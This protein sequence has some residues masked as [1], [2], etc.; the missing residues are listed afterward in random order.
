MGRLDRPPLRVSSSAIKEGARIM[1]RNPSALLD[2]V[3]AGLNFAV[4]Q[5]C[6]MLIKRLGGDSSATAQYLSEIRYNILL[7]R[8]IRN[9]LN[10]KHY[11]EMYAPELLYVIVRQ[12]K[13]NIIVET[14][15]SSGVSSAYMLQALEDNKNGHLYS[16][17][18]PNHTMPDENR[19]LSGQESG[20]VIPKDL[21]QRWSLYIGKSKDLLDP[22]LAKN[23]NIDMFVHDSEHSYENM[24][25]EYTKVWKYIKD[26]GLL[27]SH[28][29]NENAAFKDFKKIIG[30]KSYEVYFSGIGV[31]RK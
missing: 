31:I 28:D 9:K 27:L 14:G 10:G 18:Y 2:Y 13:P 4:E 15:V 5:Q 24:F 1:L 8:H 6:P 23:T 29:I 20:F 19:L 26:G 17:D 11:G 22:I 25:F 21:R 3:V 16:I 30:K 12:F 7:N